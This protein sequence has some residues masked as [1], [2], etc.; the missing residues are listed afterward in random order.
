[1]KHRWSPYTA[2]AMCGLFGVAATTFHGPRDEP[3]ITAVATDYH[4]TLPETLTA[5]AIPFRLEN[6]G[7]ELHHVFI[8]RLEHG[9]SAN[10]LAAAMKAGGPL[11]AWAI[12]VG[13]PN[14]V[15]PGATSLTTTVPLT[16]GRYAA[17][18]VIPG[19]DGVPH[20]MKGMITEFRVVPGSRKVALPAAAGA[21]V[22]LLDYTFDFSR[23][24]T[25]TTRTILVRNDGKQPHELEIA[26]LEAGKTPADLAAWA[27]KMAGPPPAHFLGGV[28]PIAPGHANELS[29]SLTAGHYVLLC[30]VP[31]AKDAKP[32]VAHGMVRGFTVR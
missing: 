5:G 29:L 16:A 12:P 6:R 22:K 23:P 31:D 27:E 9:K 3:T 10:H 20:A 4:L 24:I 26:R 19:S 7:R 21:T 8:V 17:L 13:G 18:C 25:A 28:S 15:D 1:M 14:G 30:F 11:P 32:H 2:V